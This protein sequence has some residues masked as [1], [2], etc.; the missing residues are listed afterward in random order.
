MKTQHGI[1]KVPACG[2]RQ[3]DN[4]LCLAAL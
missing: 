1:Q 3:G 2:R 4:G